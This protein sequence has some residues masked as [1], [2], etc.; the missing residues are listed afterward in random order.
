[1][2]QRPKQNGLYMIRT[3]PAI[4]SGLTVSGGSVVALCIVGIL[5]EY[6]FIIVGNMAN[7][8]FCGDYAVR[9]NGDIPVIP[10][11]KKFYCQLNGKITAVKLIAWGT[12]GRIGNNPMSA[13]LV[14]TPE[15]IVEIESWKM[16]LFRNVEDC[17]EFIN[18]NNYELIHRL[19]TKS[20][21]DVITACGYTFYNHDVM[22]YEWNKKDCTTWNHDTG[23]KV[24]SD[25]DGIHVDVE[26]E[27]P[28]QN[29]VF[30]KSSAECT[31]ANVE[32][33]DFDD[34]Y[35]SSPKGEYTVVRH[36]TVEAENEEEAE[37]FIDNVIKEAYDKQLNN[38]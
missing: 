5:K 37:K 30:F 8:P 25:V 32:V 19:E 36:F 10:A 16:K 22:V 12:F 17:V 29:R 27:C 23:V 20:S 26:M 14:Q 24:W 34:D 13:Y 2:L 9:I 11:F 33:L 28:D 7:F 4:S 3:T 35:D 6:V 1:M 18:T 38:K 31:A 21:K 15:G